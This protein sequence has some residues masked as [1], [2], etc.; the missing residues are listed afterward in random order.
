MEEV[1]EQQPRG[2]GADDAYL[3]AAIHATARAASHV[4]PKASMLMPMGHKVMH[5]AR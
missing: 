5:I 1:P 4:R 2:T 3:S